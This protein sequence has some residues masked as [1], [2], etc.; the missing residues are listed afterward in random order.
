[1]CD[2]GGWT[3]TWFAEHGAVFNIGV[4]P[5]VEV[6]LRLA[7]R[8][9]EER[10]TIT[11]ENYGDSYILNPEQVQ[12]D[13]HPLLEA[14]IDEMSIPEDI[15][16]EVTIFSAIP[17]GA[18]TGTSAAVTIALIASLDRL[19]PGR[20]TPYELAR[21]AHMIETDKLGLQC[22]IQDQIACAYGGLNFIQMHQFPHATVSRPIIP[23][24]VLLELERRLCLVYIGSPHQSS[25]VHRM[26]IED[27]EGKGKE[28]ERIEGLRKLARRAKDAASVGDFAVFGGIMN[29]NTELQRRLHPKLVCDKFEEVIDLAK[30]YGALG[31]K[32]NGAGGDGGSLTI[33]SNGV[34]S[35][36]RRM[37]N[38]LS[39]RGVGVIE[40][41]VAPRGVTVWETE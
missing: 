18:S 23:E 21:F 16:V 39:R 3:D 40:V 12:I 19:S 5:H 11:L 7:P 34:A 10:V 8:T 35:E 31:C 30:S 2:I 41:R 6:Q 1:M 37:M 17:P 32:V 25:E 14:V 22:G 38:E 29:E 36:R 24:D 28:D 26:V 27:L 15:A 33:L 4:Y 13:R 9:A 20:M